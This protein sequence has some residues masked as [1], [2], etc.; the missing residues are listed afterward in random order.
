MTL[1]GVSVGTGDPEDITV[2]AL[3]TIA[4]CRVIAV[5]VTKGGRSAALDIAA[6]AADLSGKEILRLDM[7]MVRDK[8]ALS[9]AH[10][11]AAERL[12][13]VLK[14]EDAAMLCLGDTS[15]YSTFSYIAALVKERGFGVRCVSG[16]CSPCSAANA[17]GIPL[18]LGDEPLMILPYSAKG[19][20][21]LMKT[22]CRK[23]IMKGGSSSG[24]V[25]EALRGNGLLEGACAVENCGMS[26]ERT[27]RG[28]EI[29]DEMG[30]FSIFLA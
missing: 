2:K 24:K 6:A 22:P 7:P 8:S 12:C 28:E 15:L 29:P 21:E 19:F 26:G 27:Y 20:S 9:A 4:E 5:P 16:V 11:E 10:R 23:V 1:Y 3:R 25:K 13:G 17:L 14:K 30:Y 18:A